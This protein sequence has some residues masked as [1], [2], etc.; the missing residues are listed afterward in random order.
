MKTINVLFIGNSYTSC[1]NLPYMVS[2]LALS[3]QEPVQVFVQAITRGEATLEWHCERRKAL[4]MIEEKRWN[5]VILQEYGSR[6]IE[7]KVKM[8][9]SAEILDSE[10]KKSGAE[11]VL[12]LTWARQDAP[13]MQDKLT[14]AYI[15]LGK[16]IGARVAPVGTAWANALKSDPGLVLYEEDKSHPTPT[17]TYLAACV[18]YSTFLDNSPIGLTGNIYVNPDITLNLPEDNANFLQS[19]VWKT[20]QE[21]KNNGRRAE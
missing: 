5:F 4:K 11:T 7:D 15:N 14:E 8:Y 10:I 19:I 13:E 20:V 3:A 16:K 18:F 12:F 17:G 21:F 2:Q 1:N 9:D 6:P